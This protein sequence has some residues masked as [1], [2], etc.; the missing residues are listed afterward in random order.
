MLGLYEDNADCIIEFLTISRGFTSPSL[1]IPNK[2]GFPLDVQLVY[3][4][5]FVA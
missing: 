2:D 1:E 4:D 3:W 5:A